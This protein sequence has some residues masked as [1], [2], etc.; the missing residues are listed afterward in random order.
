MTNS[1]YALKD[2]KNLFYSWDFRSSL[3][4]QLELLADFCFLKIYAVD[5]QIL[6]SMLFCKQI[7][8]FLVKLFFFVFIYLYICAFPFWKIT[9]IKHFSVCVNKG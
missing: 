4:I 2:K 7:C 3:K 6:F 8:M 5:K 9:C 1:E